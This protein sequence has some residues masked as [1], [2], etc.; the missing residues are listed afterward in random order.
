MRIGRA[1]GAHAR[2]R[3][4]A[5]LRAAA[6][7]ASVGALTAL[8][9][10]APATALATATPA[11]N[12]TGVVTLVHAV[13]G[14]IADVSV[15]GKIVLTGFT[16]SRVTDPV[17]LSAGNHTVTLKADNGSNAG[18]VVLTAT[19]N[20]IAGTT[21]TAVVGLTPSGAAK[22]YVFP[23]MPI[24]VP[25]GEAAVVV[26]HVAATGPIKLM[27]DGAALPGTLA[28]GATETTDTAPGTHHVVVESTT[29]ATILS[30]QSAPLEADR[31]TTLY[32]T[33]SQQDH[34]LA[35]V[36]TTRLASSL[37]SLSAIPTGD[38]S[39]EHILMTT[40]ADVPVGTAALIAI[41]LGLGTYVLTRRRTLTR[42]VT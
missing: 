15:D 33:G 16:A 18:K 2:P 8:P 41:A 20:I 30:A 13:P 40:R 34:S 26:R 28:N 24:S 35:W 42:A 5:T 19:L 25:N 1:R 32:L 11:L 21:S 14:L 29:G 31:V 10:L 37:T 3:S 27:V 39:S 4:K 23:E 36:A 12:S 9:L 17:T 38:G 6:I 22:A 7:G